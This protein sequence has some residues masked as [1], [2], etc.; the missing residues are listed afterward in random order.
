VLLDCEGLYEAPRC[1]GPFPFYS[2]FNAAVAYSLGC[3]GVSATEGSDRRHLKLPVRPG[4][5][6]ALFLIETIAGQK[7]W[8]IELKPVAFNTG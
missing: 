4:S 5:D 7:I 6:G 2:T 3:I 1:F 8:Q